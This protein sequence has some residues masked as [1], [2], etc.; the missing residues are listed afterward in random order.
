M[1]LPTLPRVS[2]EYSPAPGAERA[3]RIRRIQ[4]CIQRFRARRRLGNDM[5][6]LFS[7]YL[8]LGGIDAT[9]RM[10]TGMRGMDK[11]DIEGATKSE[12]RA[13]AADDIISR[14]STTKF[15]NPSRPEHWDVDFYGVAAGYL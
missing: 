11:E 4:E 6:I 10:F 15:Y 2:L 9:P 7:R 13:M 8:T 12:L 1:Q 5:T 3:D 14:T